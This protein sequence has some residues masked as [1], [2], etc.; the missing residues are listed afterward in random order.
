MGIGKT[1]S[2]ILN[3]KSVNPNELAESLN[4][5]PSTIYSIIKRDNMKVD[6]TVLAR[7]CKELDVPMERFYDEYVAEIKNVPEL[8]FTSI[9][10]AMIKKY[11]SLDKFGQTAVSNILNIEYNRCVEQKCGKNLIL[12]PTAARSEDNE[13]DIHNELSRDMSKFET[14]KTDL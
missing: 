3:E 1:L 4:I 8:V 7:I 14:D 12:T 5:A 2:E 9:E 11:R 13:I 10:K 6:I